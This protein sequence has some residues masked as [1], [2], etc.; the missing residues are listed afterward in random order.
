MWNFN[1]DIFSSPVN[2]VIE[3]QFR[4]DK[5]FQDFNSKDKL[6]SNHETGSGQIGT[7][8][9]I[10]FPQASMFSGNDWIDLMDSIRIRCIK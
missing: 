7:K 8:S 9:T 6:T 2:L 5:N 4:I 3:I 1:V 10:N